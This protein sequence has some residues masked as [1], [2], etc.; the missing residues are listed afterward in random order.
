VVRK[1]ITQTE[2]TNCVNAQKQ[3]GD[4]KTKGIE[5]YEV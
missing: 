1:R 4:G 3:E 2:V 5:S